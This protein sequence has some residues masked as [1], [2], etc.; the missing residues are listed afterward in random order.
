MIKEKALE[1]LRI[2]TDALQKLLFRIDDEFERVNKR[3]REGSEEPVF[4]VNVVPGTDV[5]EDEDG[6]TLT[7]ENG[8]VLIFN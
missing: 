5:A 4:T 7:D 3:A 6:N 1:T 8:N 2:E